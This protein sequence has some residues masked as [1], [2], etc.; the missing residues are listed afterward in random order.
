MVRLLGSGPSDPGSNP[1]SPTMKKLKKK[2]R[3]YIKRFGIIKRE[4]KKIRIA[5][6]LIISNKIN[7][8]HFKI[9]YNNLF[10]VQGK[11]SNYLVIKDE[12]CSCLGFTNII[13]R[14]KNKACYHLIAC[15]LCN[16]MNEYKLRKEQLYDIF[17]AA[18]QRKNLNLAS[19]I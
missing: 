18:Y 9:K 3:L 13:M 14:N 7:K 5:K 15:S 17:N 6:E 2:I 4:S 10:Y 1:G 19:L 8:L 16:S 11:A 12:W